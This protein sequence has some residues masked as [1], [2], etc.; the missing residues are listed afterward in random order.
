MEYGSQPATK[1]FCAIQC[2]YSSAK[3]VRTVIHFS[4]N[5]GLFIDAIYVS[6][7]VA[8]DGGMNSEY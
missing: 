2:W 4:L 8:Q 6:D 7:S 3:N 5:S 1:N